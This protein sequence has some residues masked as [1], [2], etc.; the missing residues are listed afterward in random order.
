MLA[1][2][3]PHARAAFAR[4]AEHERLAERLALLEAGVE[5]GEEGMLLVARDGR[6]RS[7]SPMGRSLLR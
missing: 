6:I 4:V 2:I 7:A 3:A 5:A 1:A